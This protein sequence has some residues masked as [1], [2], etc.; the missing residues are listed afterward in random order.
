ME[1]AE[2]E[3]ATSVS[4]R[5]KGTWWGRGR[6]NPVEGKGQKQRL[7]SSWISLPRLDVQKRVNTAGLRLSSLERA[8]CKS[9]PWPA[10]GSLAFRRKGSYYSLI[11]RAHC[12]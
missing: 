10:S 5:P 1:R 2:K 6:D 7:L 3:R 9:G 8:A 11:R 12:D 4:L